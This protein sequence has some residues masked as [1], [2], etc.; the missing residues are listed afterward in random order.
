MKTP[1]SM[2]TRAL[3]ALVLLLAMFVSAPA[4]IADDKIY[5]KDGRVLEGT[6][7]REESGY[8]W[9][10]IKYGG[11]EKEQ[12]ISP[13]EIDRVERD[14]A[15]TPATP[16]AKPDATKRS[17]PK[18][19][20]PG[21]PRI[22]MISLGEQPNKEMVGMY[23]T[24]ESLKNAIPLLEQEGVTDVV[25]KINSGG[26]FLLE[27]QRL[28]DVI[29]NDYKKRFRTVAWIESAI[30]AAA[31]TAHCVEEIYFTPQGNYGACTGWS[32]ALVAV[33]DRPLEEVLYMMEKI[34]ARGGYDPKIMRAMQIMEP[35]SCTMDERGDVHW[36]QNLTGDNI[37]NPEGKIL[38][39][40]AVTAAK[41]KFSKGTAAT[42][43]ELAKLM[44]YQEV[45]WVGTPERGSPWP[46]SKAEASIR[47]FRDRTYN[48]EQRMN[49]YFTSYQ[50]AVQRA[51]AMQEKSD[52]AKFVARASS[53]LDKIEAMV[54]NNPN[55]GLLIG[56]SAEAFKEWM[57][58]QR[59]LLRD[60]MR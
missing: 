41:Y 20:A 10:M 21:V 40:N 2:W 32:G 39:F 57:E 8:Y 44:G 37:V 56:G 58:A 30:S 51:Q 22:A 3:T 46:I 16:A 12:F 29:H 26:G 38:T 59:Q 6:I 9:I 31:M 19:R 15:A 54:R 45:E 42:H 1:S 47:Q 28:S 25:F 11:F 13:G 55:I 4:A 50:T 17:E 24:A 48:D 60:L 36:Y 43:E 34:S 18:A 5:L 35:L 53:F 33:K 27:I 7:V 49:E 14:A 23:M 52:R